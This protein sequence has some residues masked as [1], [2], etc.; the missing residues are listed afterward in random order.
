VGI[1][2]LLG[3][4]LQGIALY[5]Y[6]KEYVP[7]LEGEGCQHQTD[8]LLLDGVGIHRIRQ[9][10]PCEQVLPFLRSFNH[11]LQGV[12]STHT[13]L[14]GVIPHVITGTATDGCTG[15]IP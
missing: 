7:I 5:T 8:M 13:M 9:L 6:G 14:V 3:H 11:L 12:F 10:C 4:L 1:P 15:E 2:H